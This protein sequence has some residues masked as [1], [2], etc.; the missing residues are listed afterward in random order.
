MTLRATHF[1]AVILIALALVPAGAHVFALPN[2]IS[3]SEH[4][5]F[6]AQSVYRGWAL[7]GIVLFGA[8]FVLLALT[9]LLREQPVPFWLAIG[10]FACVAATLVIFFIWTYPANQATDNWTTIP[11]NWA[12]LRRQWEYAHAVN[13][14]L[15]FAALCV[16]TLALVLAR[17]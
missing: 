16:T 3:L 15:T 4:D 10:A 14:L 11:S 17:E 6:V 9:I 8:L 5:Y 1:L 7:F 13:A 12:E 2:K